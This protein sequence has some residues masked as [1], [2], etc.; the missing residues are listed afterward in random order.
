MPQT[1]CLTRCLG[2]LRCFY[3]YN[4]TLYQQ[5]EDDAAA[6]DER[7]R[8]A[9]DPRRVRAQDHRGS[10]EPPPLNTTDENRFAPCGTWR[11]EQKHANERARHC[12]N[13][14]H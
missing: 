12:G 3:Y 11:R 5:E 9:S 2:L 10:R 7:A 1:R 6:H 14:P 8:V 13:P 4:N